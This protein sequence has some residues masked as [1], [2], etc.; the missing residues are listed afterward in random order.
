MM[1]KYLWDSL[2]TLYWDLNN[3]KI[4]MR[5]LIGQKWKDAINLIFQSEVTQQMVKCLN[6]YERSSF[7]EEFIGH[8]FSKNFD[9]DLRQCL[10]T[11]LSKEPY[12]GSLIILLVEY[13]DELHSIKRKTKQ[14]GEEIIIALGSS[15]DDAAEA[16]NEIWNECVKNLYPMEI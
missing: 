8:P 6:S 12:A 7:I 11:N 9:Y 13:F 14:D 10:V 3:F 15:E 16:F 5:Q 2:G 1:L 4:L